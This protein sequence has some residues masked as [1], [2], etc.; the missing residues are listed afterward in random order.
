MKAFAGSKPLPVL[1]PR[2]RTFNGR[3]GKTNSASVPSSH[4]D[5]AECHSLQ[6]IATKES[7]LIPVT[8]R[9]YSIRNKP[10]EHL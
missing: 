2:G 5:L 8:R 3:A 9:A 10:S 7:L 4:M 6:S 1:F